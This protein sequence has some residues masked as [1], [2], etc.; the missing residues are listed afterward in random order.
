MGVFPLNLTM[1]DKH[2]EDAEVYRHGNEEVASYRVAGM[3]AEKGGPALVF[4]SERA[5]RAS[6]IFA[7]GAR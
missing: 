4:R 1:P 7:D 3:I 5:R 6:E 2:I